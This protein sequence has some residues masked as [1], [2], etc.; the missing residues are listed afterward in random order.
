MAGTTVRRTG[1]NRAAIYAR[2]SDKSQAEKDRTSLSEQVADMERYCEERGMTIAAR[3]EEVGR[4]WSKKR[5]EFQRMLGDAR[6]GLFDTIVCWK[7]DRLSRGVYPAAAI[8]EVVEAYG[9]EIESVMDAIDMKTFGLMAAIAKIELDG[10]RERTS[11]G[12][13]GAARRGRVP[14]G[15]LPYGYRVG[16]DGRPELVEEQAQVVRR[17]FRM[18]LGEGIST[19]SVARMLTEEGVPPARST[20]RWHHTHVSR[21]LSNEAY[22]GVWNYGRSHTRQTE[23]GI[24]IF[25]QPRESWIEVS[26]PQVVDEESWDRVQRM[27]KERQ[28]KSKRNTKTFYL[29]Q[30][31]MRCNECGMLFGAHSAWSTSSTRNGR[32]Y[33][34]DLKKPLRYYRCYGGKQSLRC[35]ERPYIRA[36]RLEELVWGE[37][38]DVLRNPE[39]IVAGIESMQSPDANGVIE[40]IASLERGQKRVRQQEERAIDL[41]VTGRVTESQFERQRGLVTERLKDLE[42]KLNECRSRQEVEADRREA[43]ESILGWAEEMGAGV[44]DITPDQQRKIL[45]GVVESITIDRHNDVNITLAISVDDP[46]S[47]EAASPQR[48][49]GLG[50]EPSGQP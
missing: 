15:R 7:P 38:R 39:L 35:R 33:R 48:L 17:I 21:I 28:R 46:L 12:R 30:H 2:V 18:Y 27:K 25:D 5:P 44:D 47:D 13:R 11:M 22:R 3:Y 50:A 32:R 24:K 16:E 9:I 31:M 37:V 14:S 36:E 23:D 6:S 34:Y 29:L 26:V 1:A 20:K 10:I 19:E 45:L 49:D 41:F 40:E 43:M 42:A 4:G 8:M